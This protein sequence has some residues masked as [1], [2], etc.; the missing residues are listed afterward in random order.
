MFVHNNG[1]GVRFAN[2]LLIKELGMKTKASKAGTED[3]G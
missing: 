2:G 1:S 3:L